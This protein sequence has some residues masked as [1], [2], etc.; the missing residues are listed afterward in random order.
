[1]FRKMKEAWARSERRYARAELEQLL[2][3]VRISARQHGIT[4]Q[5][6]GRDLL[7][8]VPSGA[9]AVL[10]NALQDDDEGHPRPLVIL[11][12]WVREGV[13]VTQTEGHAVQAIRRV[14]SEVGPYGRGV[15][16]K[17]TRQPFMAFVEYDGRP[18]TRLAIDRPITPDTADRFFDMIRTQRIRELAEKHDL[19]MEYAAV[20]FDG[21]AA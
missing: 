19:P 13:T 5:T 2:H 15:A 9:T 11:E 21:G 1:M 7:F 14:M 18:R 6:D 17:S 16:E 3:G 10:Q 8:P 4:E 12:R 20:M